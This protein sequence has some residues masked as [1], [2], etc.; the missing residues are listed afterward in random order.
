MTKK[1]PST[2]RRYFIP[3]CCSIFACLLV[4]VGVCYKPD[5]TAKHVSTVTTAEPQ[6]CA[7]ISAS[8]AV[9]C[10]GIIYF[11]SSLRVKR[12]TWEENFDPN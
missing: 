6:A 2:R 10:R 4:T 5:A 9:A 12:L 3:T 8:N 7:H 11:L 1:P